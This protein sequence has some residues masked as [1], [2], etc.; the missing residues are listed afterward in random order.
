MAAEHPRSC[1]YRGV[2]ST[3]TL[4]AC[5][6]IFFAAHVRATTVT[7]GGV[8]YTQCGTTSSSVSTTVTSI[9]AASSTSG[10]A[11]Y[12]VKATGC[13]GCE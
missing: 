2:T 13:P 4:T 9:S 7:Y 12:Q 3:Q 5:L 10:V 8:T 1:A 11:M 6:V